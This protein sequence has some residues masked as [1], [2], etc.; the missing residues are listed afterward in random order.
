MHRHKVLFDFLH[1]F[2]RIRFEI[3]EDT[4][5]KLEHHIEMIRKERRGVYMGVINMMIVVPMLVETLTFG[6][7]FKHLLGNHPANALQISIY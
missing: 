2:L 6:P 1:T 7:I 4:T 5:C 3:A